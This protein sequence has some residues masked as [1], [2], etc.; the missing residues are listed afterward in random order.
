[1]YLNRKC[2][3]IKCNENNRYDIVSDC[4]L[5][6]K[7]VGSLN[8][9]PSDHK[10]VINKTLTEQRI[11]MQESL[12]ES[13]SHTVNSGNSNSMSETKSSTFSESKV[14]SIGDSK[15]STVETKERI[16]VP[17]ESKTTIGI[18]PPNESDVM[19]PKLPPD[20]FKRPNTIKRVQF[21]K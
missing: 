13:K 17:L 21:S 6:F 11:R 18:N 15:R 1:M 5:V 9:T 14:S 19:P 10:I 4:N 20:D 8:L 12:L 16:L 3:I 7:D 2:E